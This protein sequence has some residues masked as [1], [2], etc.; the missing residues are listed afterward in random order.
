MTEPR[1]LCT[2][3]ERSLLPCPYTISSII[4]MSSLFCEVLVNGSVRRARSYAGPAARAEGLV[5]LSYPG[6]LKPK[7]PCRVRAGIS[8]H[9]V[10]PHVLRRARGPPK[11]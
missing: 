6:H 9:A 10:T 3:A 1:T 7:R 4:L 8:S 5:H 2:P 11:R